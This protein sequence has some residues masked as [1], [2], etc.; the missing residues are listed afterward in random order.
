MFGKLPLPEE[1]HNLKTQPIKR[2]IPPFPHSYFPLFPLFIQH[3]CLG[4]PFTQHVP[5]FYDSHLHP[6][7]VE[8]QS[9]KVSYILI[10]IIKY[11]IL[12]QIALSLSRAV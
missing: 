3:N 1:S 10:D 5:L 7:K 9:R 11:F 8:A 6:K 2:K 12:R 4:F